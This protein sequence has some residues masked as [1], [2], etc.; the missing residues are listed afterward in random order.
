MRPLRA[1]HVQIDQS[2]GVVVYEAQDP[3]AAVDLAIAARAPAPYGAVLWDSAIDVARLLLRWDLRGRRVVD[4]GCG[5]GLTVIAAALRGAR[6]HATDVDEDVFPAVHRAAHDQGLDGLVS[7]GCFDVCGTAA[8]PEADDV[9]I[10]DLLY[11]PALAAAVARRSLEAWRRGSRV[12]VGDPERAGRKDFLQLLAGAVDVDFSGNVLV[13]D[14]E[15]PW[16]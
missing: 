6:V 3:G 15:Q 7:T 13:L 11:E 5:C 1:R 14:Q 8:L 10:A 9:V 12:V 16:P 2:T 4:L